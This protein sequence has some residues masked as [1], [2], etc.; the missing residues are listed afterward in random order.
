MS[1]A[2]KLS[3]FIRSLALSP[4]SHSG[5]LLSSH[6]RSAVRKPGCMKVWGTPGCR[7]DHMVVVS[8]PYDDYILGHNNSASFK[9]ETFNY[10]WQGWRL[11]IRELVSDFLCWQ[12]TQS[13]PPVSIRS[14]K[15]QPQAHA[16]DRFHLFVYGSM[17]QAVWFGHELLIHL[18]W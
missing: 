14:A 10:F 9:E 1:R 7:L 17:W 6:R 15:W 4:G 12:A 16:R 11:R 2:N 3:L 8:I 18:T 5:I 13:R